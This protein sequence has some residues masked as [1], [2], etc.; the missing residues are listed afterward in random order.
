MRRVATGELPKR[1]RNCVTDQLTEN[2]ESSL[3][4]FWRLGQLRQEVRAGR[5]A[6]DGAE[7][8]APT[9]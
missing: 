6:S 3:S 7:C 9:L 4:G 5:L 2:P 8:E 1:L